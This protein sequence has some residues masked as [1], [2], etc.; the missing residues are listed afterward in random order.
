[1]RTDALALPMAPVEATACDCRT[2]L[3][4]DFVQTRATHK[5]LKIRADIIRG[6]SVLRARLFLLPPDIARRHMA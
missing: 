3:A 1:M 5:K 2:V 6:A 4:A